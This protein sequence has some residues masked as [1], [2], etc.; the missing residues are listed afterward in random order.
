MM[1]WLTQVWHV[2][3]KDVRQFRWLL[4]VQVLATAMAVTAVVGPSSH[5]GGSGFPRVFPTSLD[6]YLVLVGLAVL[7]S[8]V[9]VQADSPSRSDAFWASRPLHPL[10]VRRGPHLHSLCTREAVMH[11]PLPVGRAVVTDHE[12]RPPSR[13]P[14]R[15]PVGRKL[16][17]G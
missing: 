6:W 17:R 9:V 16:L 2:V 8:A 12:V 3:K 11:I 4:V 13:S 5:M 10:A 15:Q 7:I 1:S 14:H